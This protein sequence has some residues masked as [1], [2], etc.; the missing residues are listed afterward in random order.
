MAAEL[1]LEVRLPEG[2][3]VE[4]EGADKTE[5][6]EPDSPLLAE[7]QEQEP[8]RLPTRQPSRQASRQASW[9]TRQTSREPPRSP[10]TPSMISQRSQPREREK[11]R[12]GWDTVL[13]SIKR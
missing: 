1:P 8:K 2:N 5:Q 13:R 4:T 6:E 12:G 7:E 9:I 3:G 11:G 10:L